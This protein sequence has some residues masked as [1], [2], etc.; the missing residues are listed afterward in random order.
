MSKFDN[1][2]I[3]PRYS[4]IAVVMTFFG[5]AVIGR[6]IYIMSA[7]H[8]YWM[9][10]SKKIESNDKH[11]YPERGNILSDNGELLA[12]SLPEYKLVID[13]KVGG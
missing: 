3:I 10:V 2:K 9:E 7:K 12:S 11:L 5:V 4:L 1:H 6:T 13:F 8:D